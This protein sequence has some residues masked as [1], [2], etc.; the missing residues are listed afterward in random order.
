MFCGNKRIQVPNMGKNKPFK[1]KYSANQNTAITLTLYL[2]C[3][4]YILVAFADMDFTP[5]L[6]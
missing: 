6:L 2:C 3:C 5:V 4:K 1:D